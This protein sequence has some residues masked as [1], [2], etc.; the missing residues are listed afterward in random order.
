VGE[1]L[2]LFVAAQQE[3]VMILSLA[4]LRLQAVVVAL[5]CQQ[6]Q[7]P[8]VLLEPLAVLVEEVQ[9]IQ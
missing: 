6:Q 8:M 1:P 9:P 7:I 2:E 3:K 4:P 5:I